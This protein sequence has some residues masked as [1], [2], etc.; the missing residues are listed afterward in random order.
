MASTQPPC[1][2]A[3]GQFT[4]IANDHD[5]HF[6][7]SL[8]D[9]KLSGGPT[10][11]YTRSP[12]IESHHGWARKKMNEKVTQRKW[13]RS[14]PTFSPSSCLGPSFIIDRQP[15]FG[16]FPYWDTLIYLSDT[17]LGVPP[18]TNTKK[19]FPS[20]KKPPQHFKF[21]LT[22]QTTLIQLY[23]LMW[24]LYLNDMRLSV[25]VRRVSKRLDYDF[26]NSSMYPSLDWSFLSDLHFLF[27]FF[28]PVVCLTSNYC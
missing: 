20:D 12:R 24:H 5:H 25:P 11:F 15:L 13:Q 8:I 9:R 28:T 27:L 17:W 18:R 19:T 1:R 23:F 16:C 2:F 26:K 14:S 7:K 22:W 6:L 21:N 3:K 10:S 4:L